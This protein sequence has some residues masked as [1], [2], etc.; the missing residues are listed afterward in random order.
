MGLRGFGR[1]R[2]RGARTPDHRLR[3]CARHR[4]RGR[5]LPALR[6]KDKALWPQAPAQRGRG[7]R[8]HAGRARHGAPKAARRGRSRSR[9]DRVVRARH[10]AADGDRRAAQRPPARPDPRG[11]PGRSHACRRGG[12]GAARHEAARPLPLGVAGARARRARA[13]VLRRPFRGCGR[14]G[15]RPLG[16]QRARDPS[17]RPRAAARLHGT[18]LEAMHDARI[19]HDARFDAGSARVLAPTSSTGAKKAAST[20]T[21]SRAP[22]AA[23]GSGRS[24]PSAPQ[25][26]T[27]CCA[28]T[29]AL[30]CQPRSSAGSKTRACTCASTTSSPAAA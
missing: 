9:A 15:A 28:A 14:G 4:R 11:I 8:S 5:N 26:A 23:S 12:A 21:C 13:D 27:S 19:V 6:A 30:C 29:S 25:S 2:R 20:S 16:R 7:R 22:R 24:S 18:P 17:S 3:A 10:G 1:E